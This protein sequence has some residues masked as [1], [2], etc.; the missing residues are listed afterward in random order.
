MQISRFYPDKMVGDQQQTT[1]PPDP[2][3]H[4]ES[5]AQITHK[6]LEEIPDLPP[7]VIPQVMGESVTGNPCSAQTDPYAPY[8]SCPVEI[9]FESASLAIDL[10]KLEALKN[11]FLSTISHELRT[12]LSNIYLSIQLLEILLRRVGI[13]SV[14]EQ[15][16]PADFTQI[17]NCLHTV[18]DAC[19]H[20]INLVDDLL[21]I[22]QL[23]L[24]PPLPLPVCLALADWFTDLMPALQAIAQHYHQHLNIELPI[25]PVHVFTDP[26]LV[27][28]V[29]TELVTNACK[30]TPIGQN[31]SLTV[32]T[33]PNLLEIAIRNP[34]DP[35]PP[36]DTPHIFDKF[37][38]I[39]GADPWKQG[40]MGIGLTLAQRLAQYLGGVIWLERIG[41]HNQFT[42]SLPCENA[43]SSR[44]SDDLLMNY[45]AYYLSLGKAIVSRGDRLFFMGTVYHYWGLHPHFLQFWQR[46]QQRPD[47][48]ELSLEKDAYSFGQFLRKSCTVQQCSH[49]RQLVP[50]KER[51]MPEGGGCRL[52]EGESGSDA[53][54]WELPS[55]ATPAGAIAPPA[56]PLPPCAERT[57]IATEDSPACFLVVGQPSDQDRER[58]QTFAQNGFQVFFIARPEELE[59]DILS[60]PIEMVIL[61]DRLSK[62]DGELLA[63]QIRCFY[64]LQDVP[65]IAFGSLCLSRLAQIHQRQPL[66]DYILAPIAGRNL[67]RH[68]RRLLQEPTTDPL[69]L[70]WFPC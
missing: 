52:C 58:Q 48:N 1:P 34:G 45:V 40:G 68:L 64:Q 2:D 60:H 54:F 14:E 6:A 41:G 25:Q 50:I 8:P 22:Q 23:E 12:P 70:H 26:A 42:L 11:D 51:G 35:I 61:R 37:R 24:D 67:A 30:F 56:S 49:C 36:E 43:A 20:E 15:P 9:A 38:R 17:F 5:S 16:T 65:I 4:L 53:P 66:E 44:D 31:I 19:K 21:M 59:S 62:Q 3:C 29:V 32:Q 57:S 63:R 55:G 27:G 10:S 47:F 28:R 39:P 46:L 13:S 7:Q 33:S 69:G 18:Q